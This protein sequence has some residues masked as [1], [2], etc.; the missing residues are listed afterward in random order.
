MLALLAAL[1]LGA[2]DDGWSVAS[3]TGDVE[4]QE[5]ARPGSRVR[6][7]QTVAVVD[8]PP[9]V[10]RRVVTD[11]ARYPEVMPYTV[12]GRVVATEEGGR[13][14]HLY[15]LVDPPLVARRDYTMRLVDEG[16]DASG[17]LRISWT[18]SD[19]GPPPRQGVVRVTVNEGRWLLEPIDGGARTR[20]TYRLHTDPG[21]TVP[22]FAANLANRE[23]LP[24]VLQAVRR[25][26]GDPRYRDPPPAR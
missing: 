9:A 14:V 15:T 23:A 25:A 5:R 17:A 16:A 21:G 10:V 12:E 3:R 22:G 4:V 13:V 11:W 20:A 6:E 18:P 8:A 1:L 2:P 7:V 26:A 24:G 19:R